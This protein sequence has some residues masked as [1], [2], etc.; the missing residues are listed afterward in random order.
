MTEI[1]AAA[2]N[3][4]QA[5][6]EQRRTEVEALINSSMAQQADMQT[7]I[8]RLQLGLRDSEERHVALLEDTEQVGWR[9][10]KRCFLAKKRL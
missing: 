8:T 1:Q 7:R 5:A 10:N 9:P 3:A 6:E 2:R 4:L